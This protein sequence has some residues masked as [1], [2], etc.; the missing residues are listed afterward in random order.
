MRTNLA[1][2]LRNQGNENEP[3]AH[4]HKEPDAGS[5][6]AFSLSLIL[7]GQ[8][9]C[10]LVQPYQ[11]LIGARRAERV[12]WWVKG[13]HNAQLTDA[14]PFEGAWLDFEDVNVGGGTTTMRVFV[15]HMCVS[16]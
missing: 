8:L 14:Q 9:E 5:H 3:P 4:R 12:R 10:D 6:H 15:L 7:P 16:R 11:G 2:P 1:N 13:Y